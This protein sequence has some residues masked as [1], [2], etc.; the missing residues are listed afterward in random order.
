[1]VKR[2]TWLLL[3]AAAIAAGASS[4]ARAQAADTAVAT[5]VARVDTVAGRQEFRPPLSPGRAFLYSLVLPGSAQAVLGRGRTGALIMAF[6]SVALVMIRES[7]LG[8]RE[9]RRNVADSVI[10]G[11]VDA[12]GQPAVRYERTP[13]SQALIR[14]RQEQLEDWIAVMVGNHLFSALD[15]FV[16]AHLWDVPL[17]VTVRTEARTRGLALRLYW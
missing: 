5:A 11:Y 10:V 3:A 8:L 13:F 2:C 4:H 14:T 15:A 7:A 17:E 9:A 12:Q 1:M 6:E 16:A